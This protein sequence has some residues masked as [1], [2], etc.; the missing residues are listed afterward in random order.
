MDR[1]ELVSEDDGCRLDQFV[2]Q[3]LGSFSRSQVE[4]W[5]R[6][7]SVIVN[8]RQAKPGYK[9]AKGD[10]VYITLPQRVP[11]ALEPWEH[12]LCVVHEDPDCVVIDKPAGL[13]VH[14]ATSY[15]Q[16]TLV[17]ALLARFP[18]MT[19]MVDLTTVEGLRPGIVHR[20]D[21]DTSGLLVIA[22]NQGAR[23][24]LQHQFKTRQVTKVYL[25]LVYGRLG[26]STGRIVTMM[27]RDPRNR[28]RMAVV[29]EGRQ[30]VTEYEVLQFLDVPFGAPEPCTLAK[31]HL[32]TGRTHQIRVHFSH[33][34][35]PLVGDRVYGRRK[36]RIASP[37]QFLHAHQLGFWHPRSSEWLFFE[38]RLP[39]DLQAVLSRLQVVH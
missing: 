22:Q 23:K 9:L 15:R 24:A 1:I 6:A 26:E 30:A 20:L 39:D 34:G 28:K 4:K 27:G 32:L 2:T 8:D 7:G 5:I 25:A 33:I 21:K 18:K 10:V 29:P 16:D 31:V 11:Q 37:R 36:Q 35:H 38:S 3:S 13:V 17:N 14:P 12:P 19:E